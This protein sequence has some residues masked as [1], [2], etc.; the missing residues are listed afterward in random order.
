MREY[1]NKPL[2]M[3]A[4]NIR[5]FRN[6]SSCYICGRKYKP[7]DENENGPVRDHCHITDP[8]CSKAG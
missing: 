5:D 1:F 8:G 3:T 4:E 7:E 6:S 2:K